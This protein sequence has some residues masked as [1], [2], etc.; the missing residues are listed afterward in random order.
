M[1]ILLTIL[2]AE[3][4]GLMLILTLGIAIN[5]RGYLHNY[6]RASKIIIYTFAS[7]DQNDATFVV[8]WL[9]FFNLYRE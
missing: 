5:A 6:S 4:N 2:P 1:M 7:A 9:L 3:L 8:L